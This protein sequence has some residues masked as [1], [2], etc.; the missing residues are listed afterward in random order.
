MYHDVGAPE[1]FRPLLESFSEP[2]RLLDTT[3]L[4]CASFTVSGDRGSYDIS[5]TAGPWSGEWFG[6]PVNQE[7][8]CPAGEVMTGIQTRNGD[9]VDAISFDCSDLAITV[10]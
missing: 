7:F 6:K 2:G 3:E 4:R 1:F 10:K 8:A 5:R 9:A